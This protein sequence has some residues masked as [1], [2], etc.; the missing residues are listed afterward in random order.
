MTELV[1]QERRI[2]FD[3]TRENAE[4][5]DWI[6]M[7]ADFETAYKASLEDAVA[8][9]RD[10]EAAPRIFSRVDSVR[11]RSDDGVTAVTEQ[12]T[13]VRVFGICF[14]SDLVFRIELERPG[15]SEAVIR[16]ESIA[17]DGS[18]LK[19]SGSWSLEE[20]VSGAAPVTYLRYRA[21]NWVAPRSIGQEAAMR[22]FGAQDMR[23]VLRELGRA[24]EERR[25][26]GAGPRPRG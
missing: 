8:I 1:G 7:R 4:G 16:F 14:I 17:T 9:I 12:R 20:L 15:P 22:A 6:R 5:R 18:L 21:D 19:S 25:G 3:V 11:L 24:L 13:A 26:R 23:K 10:F 2:D